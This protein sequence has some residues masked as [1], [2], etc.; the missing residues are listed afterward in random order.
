MNKTMRW[1]TLAGAGVA[2]GAMIG[3]SPVQAAPAANPAAGTTSGGAVQSWDYY[4]DYVF[5]PFRN[6]PQC[7]RFGWY[8]QRVDAWDRFYC[9]FDWEP[10]SGRGWYLKVKQAYW[11]YDE[12]DGHFDNDWP[13]KPKFIGG[14]LNFDHPHKDKGFPWWKDKNKHIG[15]HQHDGPKN[16]TLPPNFGH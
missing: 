10:G 11:Q 6:K 1:L 4:D 2:A 5:G 16:I 15:D 7:L 14:P 13:Y 3:S 12:W 8:G 9:Y